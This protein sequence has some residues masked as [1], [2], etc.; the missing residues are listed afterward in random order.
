MGS[1]LIAR[2]T[3]G[4]AVIAAVLTVAAFLA[5]EMAFSLA[6]AAG[7]ARGL[8]MVGLAQ[9]MHRHFGAWS[10]R[11]F[12]W[13]MALAEAAMLLMTAIGV[14]VEPHLGI[15]GVTS[16]VAASAQLIGFGVW[17]FYGIATFALGVRGATQPRYR[18]FAIFLIGAAVSWFL[19][20]GILAWPFILAAALLA[21]SW[22][23]LKR[24]PGARVGA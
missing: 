22:S 20:V 13:L 19:V 10:L 9:D 24:S 18:G 12:A 14:P 11:W 15:E 6:V 1:G 8:V 23:F 2:L 7:G 21:L 3:A 16:D 4:M 17:L 5:P